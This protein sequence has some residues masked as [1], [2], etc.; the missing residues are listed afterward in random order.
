MNAELIDRVRQVIGS[1][2]ENQ[3]SIAERIGIA[4]DKLSKSLNGVRRFTSLELALIAEAGETTVDWLLTGR[5]ARTLAPAARTHQGYTATFSDTE[6]IL[7]RYV[8]VIDGLARV[9]H[10]LPAPP[11]PPSHS[12]GRAVDQGAELARWASRALR[13]KPAEQSARTMATEWE[14]TFGVEI[15]AIALP[16]HLDGLACQTDDFQLIL[17]ARTKNWTR[18]RFTAAHELGHIL[19][20]DA[21]HNPI[22]E[23]MAPGMSNSLAEVRANAFAAEL[24]MPATTLRQAADNPLRADVLSLAWQYRVSPS[25]MA[26]RLAT[27]GLIDQNQ[28]REYT[29]STT[30]D[31]AQA[32]GRFDEHMAWAQQARHGWY[33]GRLTSLAIKAYAAGDMSIRPLAALLD[34]PAD[35]LL[36]LFESPGPPAPDEP[37]P[38]TPEMAFTP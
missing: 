35:E 31:S 10:P 27:L 30:H 37:L 3:N 11:A 7:N 24:L 38:A 17:I 21:R 13:N 4:P 29:R 16:E 33:P 28:R 5:E 15:A 2:G 20:G 34:V 19:A 12:T 8:D 32:A 23:S 22:A 6:T 9:G 36:D 25:A 14:E 18:Q 1:T 26:T